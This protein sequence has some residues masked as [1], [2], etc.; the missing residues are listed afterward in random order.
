MIYRRVT[1][2][3]IKPDG[4]TL[5]GTTTF[6]TSGLST[7]PC[8]AEPPFG[9]SCTVVLVKHYNGS[10][11]AP[12]LLAQERHTF[13]RSP[14]ESTILSP[15]QYSSWRTGRE[16]FAE[17]LAPNE[18][19][20]RKVQGTWAQ[21]ASIPWWTATSESA[22][23]NDPRIT[24]TDTTLV[25][26]ATPKIARQ[27]FSYSADRFNNRTDVNETDYG[28][29]GPGSVL[30][31]THVEFNTLA[32]YTASNLIA[33]PTNTSLQ[34]KTYLPSL[35]S[36]EWICGSG[37]GNCVESAAVAKTEFDYDVGSLVPRTGIVG[38]QTPHVPANFQVAAERGNATAIRRWRDQPTSVWLSEQRIYDVTGN[39]TSVTDPNNN[40]TTISYND[41]FSDGVNRNTFA[42]P[43][44]VT[45]PSPFSFITQTK[46]DYRLGRPTTFTDENGVSTT[47]TYSDSL[48][49]LTQAVAGDGGA[50]G[51]R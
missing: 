40:T 49:R 15:I 13:Q 51:P 36:K 41:D 29:S 50:T 44:M 18:S 47:F 11:T 1:E 10:A 32:A 5:E 9:T 33:A 6:A 12:S 7:T 4:A 30:R 48:D 26:G 21:R 42:F 16:F 2:R 17:T 8:E 38:Y 20:L 3:R 24:Q 37:T 31:R 22:P 34:L 14:T 35:R 46:Y 43:T 19:L 27:T 28:A 39:V 45:Q 25:S 23:P